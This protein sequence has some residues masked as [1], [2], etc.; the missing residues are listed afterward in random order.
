VLRWLPGLLA[1]LVIGAM[2]TTKVLAGVVLDLEKAAP[3]AAVNNVPDPNLKLASAIIILFSGCLSI[4][5][6]GYIIDSI[7]PGE[8]PIYRDSLT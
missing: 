2:T 7:R 6:I 3:L 4:L 5:F 8:K 1:W